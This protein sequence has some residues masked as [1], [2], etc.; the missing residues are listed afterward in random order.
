MEFN[1]ILT[2]IIPHG[3]KD[4]LISNGLPEQW[5][6]ILDIFYLGGCIHRGLDDRGDLGV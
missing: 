1:P 3:G 2:I 4:L 6:R 5:A